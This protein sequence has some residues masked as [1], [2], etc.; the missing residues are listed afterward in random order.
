MPLLVLI[1]PIQVAAPLVALIGVLAELLL[2]LKYR[3]AFNF[4]SVSVLIVASI[5]GYSG[6]GLFVGMG[7]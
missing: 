1:L 4:R 6:G 7:R 5:I 2:L 3:E